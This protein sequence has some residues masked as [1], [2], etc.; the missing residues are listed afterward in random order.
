MTWLCAFVCQPT[1]ESSSLKP[2]LKGSVKNQCLKEKLLDLGLRSQKQR[3]LWVVH[4]VILKRSF[5]KNDPLEHGRAQPSA[6]Y[7]LFQSQVLSL[8]LG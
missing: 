7:I 3:P 8:R 1:I 6:I 5:S 2:I 4:S